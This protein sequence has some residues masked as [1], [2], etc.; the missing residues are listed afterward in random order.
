M[1][2]YWA[3]SAPKLINENNFETFDQHQALTFLQCMFDGG[4]I[5]IRVGFK[6]F[7]NK[8]GLSLKE[9]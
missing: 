1:S 2:I 3:P 5:W 7:K 6:L 9:N 8:F 4:I